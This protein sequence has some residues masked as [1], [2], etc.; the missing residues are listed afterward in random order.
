ME[1]AKKDAVLALFQKHQAFPRVLS[2]KFPHV[3][4]KII[5]TWD[6]PSASEQCFES[7]MLAD[8]RRTQGFPADAM[9]EIFALSRLHDSVH[10]RKSTSPFDIW[11]ASQDPANFKPWKDDNPI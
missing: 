11:G 10:T 4:A 7:L 5:E 6:S 9:T 2:E 1:A 8:P 3:L